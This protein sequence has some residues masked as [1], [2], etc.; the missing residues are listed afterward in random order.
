MMSEQFTDSI[1][2]TELCEGDSLPCEKSDIL[3]T[4]TLNQSSTAP[5]E[6]LEVWYVEENDSIDKDGESDE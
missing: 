4:R 2:R 1:R 3:H 5:T 6:R